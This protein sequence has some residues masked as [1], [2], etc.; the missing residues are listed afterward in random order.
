MLQTFDISAKSRETCRAL[1]NCQAIYR[2]FG[3]VERRFNAMVKRNSRKTRQLRK[4]E[5]LIEA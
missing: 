1:R 2:A 5:I 3:V 4:I